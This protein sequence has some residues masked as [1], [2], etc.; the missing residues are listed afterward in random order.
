MAD[1]FSITVY[2][3]GESAHQDADTTFESEK[4]EIKADG[5]LGFDQRAFG[6]TTWGSFS[7]SGPRL[8]FEVVRV[9]SAAPSKRRE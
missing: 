2:R 5:S 6:A 4:I 7:A 3:V 8:S 9:P 1:K